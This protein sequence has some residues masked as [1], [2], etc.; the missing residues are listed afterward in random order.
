MHCDLVETFISPPLESEREKQ[1]NLFSCVRGLMNVSV[2]I[3]NLCELI[4]IMA[5]MLTEGIH[6]L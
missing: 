4:K 5:G 1:V 6:L 3:N 2:A